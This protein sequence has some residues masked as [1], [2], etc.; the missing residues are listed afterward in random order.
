MSSVPKTNLP[1]VDLV[2]T[3]QGIPIEVKE[4][5]VQ[6]LDYKSRYRLRVCS[7]S[8]KNLVEFC[9]ISLEEMNIYLA[10]MQ[11]NLQISHLQIKH[12]DDKLLELNTNIIEHFFGIFKSNSSTVRSLIFSFNPLDAIQSTKMLALIEKLSESIKIRAENVYFKTNGT[13]NE[14]F[15]KIFGIFKAK[16]LHT[17]SF[18]QIVPQQLVEKLVETDGWKCAKRVY[19]HGKQDIPMDTVLHLDLMRFPLI[20]LDAEDASKLVNAFVSRKNLKPGF[21]FRITYT[22]DLTEEQIAAEF[23]TTP[24]VVPFAYK[25]ENQ[26]KRSYHFPTN[27]HGI[28]FVLRMR[29]SAFGCKDFE[30]YACNQGEDIDQEFFKYGSSAAPDHVRMNRK[31]YA[32]VP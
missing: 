15:L 5:I 13:S 28:V 14:D 30:A 19:L 4:H 23:K 7:K 8:D 22:C 1:M 24:N 21:G 26:H 20:N 10:S 17:I 2:P 3:W 11:E 12:G 25:H 31:V 6:L 27:T 9:P 32:G 18:R 29:K 16:H